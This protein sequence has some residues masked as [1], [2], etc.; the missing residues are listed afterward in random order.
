MGRGAPRALLLAAIVALAFLLRTTQATEVF[1]GDRVVLAENDPWYHLRRILL[2]LENLPRVPGFDP[3]IDHPHGAPV[4]FAPLFDLAIAL[5]AKATGA[6]GDP[7]AV[8]ALAAFVPPVLG[9]LTCLPTAALAAR[10]AQ[11]AAALPAALL[12]AL[13]PAHAW[14]S[15]IGFV[16]HHV[17]VTLLQ[18]ILALLAVVA[19]GLGRAATRARLP[20]PGAT[21]AATA[22]LACGVLAWNGFPLLLAVLDAGLLA[23]W[24]AS[25]TAGRR[26]IAR[27][28]LALHAGAALLVLPGVLSVVSDTG[29]PV[30]TRTLSLAHPA[31]LAAGAAVA[32]A[33]LLA[34]TPGGTSAASA[35]AILAALVVGAGAARGML[36]ETWSWIFARND[37]FMG[38][39]QESL[40]ILQGPDGRLDF[41]GPQ[42]WMTRFF[43]AA[44]LLLAAAGLRIERSRTTEPDRG[45][46][47]LLAWTVPLL[48]LVL[49][50]RRFGETA[51]PAL[52]VLAADA[53]VDLGAFV[54]RASRSRGVGVGAARTLGAAVPVAVA[55]FAVWPYHGALLRSP[56]RLAS[57]FRAPVLAGS[58]DRANEA[59]LA[60]REDSDDLRSVQALARLDA[61][62]GREE[63]AG[64]AP[65]GA[66]GAMNSWP[67]GHKLLAVAGLPVTATP[68]GSYVGGT[69][70]EDTTDFMLS[71][72]E[73]TALG[74][75]SRRG[76]R[77]VVIDDRLGTIGASIVGRGGNPRDW[78]DRREGPAG[79][80]YSVRAP[81][82]HSTWF[83]LVRLGGAESDVP[84]AEGRR[85]KVPALG[86]FRLV[87]DSAP[88]GAPGFVQAWEVVP[89]ARLS[90]RTSPGV[91]VR[92]SYAWTS[93]AGRERRYFATAVAD[94]RGDARLLLPYSSERADLGQFS[95]WRLEIPGHA[96]DLA[97]EES[98][99]REGRELR[100]DLGD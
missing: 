60:A 95:T 99:V 88:D 71:G 35:A 13:F 87:V 67:L 39:V 74:I 19:T 7:R 85:E 33:G 64:G 43:L 66:A 15:R 4:V 1:V 69:A 68:F 53:L 49:L 26:S 81:L 2:S 93:D 79:L 23:A 34:S 50:Q 42:V 31:A 75:L 14:Y 96:L 72:D 76:S 44:P 63:A 11:P 62:L 17:A 54:R 58:T 10:A 3:W 20:R 84:V 38:A 57:P 90:V 65:R 37:P 48:A 94:D 91:E 6:A 29:E 16:D 73:A 100:V 86:R 89:G 27:F 80:E 24:V 59:D 55:A 40:P 25:D 47:F 12:L 98:A 18:T 8:A 78:Y 61:V 45:R 83:R 28:A 22:T 92:A 21:A 97:V 70:F 30:A 9:A 41:D 36:G 5:L 82:A 51:A 52:A 56:G 77:W 46:V 32:G